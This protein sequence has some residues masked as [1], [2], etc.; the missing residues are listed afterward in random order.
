MSVQPNEFPGRFDRTIPVTSRVKPLSALTAVT[1]N[2][3][4]QWHR[5]IDNQ[6]AVN[7]LFSYA[8]LPHPVVEAAPERVY[9]TVADVDD[10]AGWLHERGGSV[11]VGPEFEGYRPYVLHTWTDARS[12]GFQVEIR[13]SCSV[14]VAADVLPEVR[15]AVTA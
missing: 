2:F 14:P 12:D 6:I 1:D 9:V 8:D 10:L 11:H 7:G 15:A 4:N 5:K 13:V 3:T